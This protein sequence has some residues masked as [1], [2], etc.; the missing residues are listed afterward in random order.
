MGTPAIARLLDEDGDAIVCVFAQCDGY[1]EDFGQDVAN[2]VGG[3]KV[4]NGLKEDDSTAS[5]TLNELAAHM[6]RNLKRAS[7]RGH[8]YLVP[9]KS[10]WDWQFRYTISPPKSSSLFV[11][12]GSDLR[13]VVEGMDYSSD[14]PKKLY[15]GNISGYSAFLQSYKAE[16]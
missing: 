12:N 4:V 8:I 10:K 7:P 5:N 16:V 2:W 3:R 9:A 1:P 13:I 6:V 15:D 14:K 11:G